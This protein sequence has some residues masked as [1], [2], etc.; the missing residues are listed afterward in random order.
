MRVWVISTPPTSSSS[1]T[2]V[3][4]MRDGVRLSADVYQPSPGLGGP[5]HL[6]ALL[7]HLPYRKDDSLGRR[8]TVRSASSSCAAASCAFASTFAATGSS[9]GV[10][11][12]DESTRKR[13]RKTVPL[14]RSGSHVSHGRTG[15]SA[16]G[17]SRT[18]DSPRC[19]S[20]AQSTAPRSARFAPCMPDGQW[21]DW[22]SA[23]GSLARSRPPSSRATPC[24]CWPRTRCRRAGGATSSSRWRRRIDATPPW[25]LRWMREQVDGPYW[26]NGSLAPDYARIRVPLSSSSPAT[27]TRTEPP[28]CARPATSKR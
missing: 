9:E 27:A 12:E 21:M 22:T 7:E 17:A 3:S 13:S 4:M 25:V 11:A 1:T 28:R 14:R 10:A 2:S 20:P 23:T 26:R 24:E 15:A 18:A 16:C 6:P 5:E 19:R 8:R